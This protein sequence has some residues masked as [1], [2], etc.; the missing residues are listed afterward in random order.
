MSQNDDE[1][2]TPAEVVHGILQAAQDFCTQTIAGN[3]NYKKGRSALRLNIKLDRHAGIRGADNGG[4]GA[5]L[6]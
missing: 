5:L 1:L 3:A 2:Q 4:E 6:W